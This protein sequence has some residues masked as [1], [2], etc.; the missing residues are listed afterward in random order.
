[1]KNKKFLIVMDIL[2]FFSLELVLLTGKILKNPFIKQK[3]EDTNNVDEVIETSADTMIHSSEDSIRD[4][5]NLDKTPNELYMEE[6]TKNKQ[7][8][9]T[10]SA[11]ET[12]NNMPV[13]SQNNGLENSSE[14]QKNIEIENKLEKHQN[15]FNDNYTSPPSK[16]KDDNYSQFIIEKTAK[17]DWNF[18]GYQYG[19]IYILNDGTAYIQTSYHSK[20]RTLIHPKAEIGYY[21]LKTPFQMYLKV[22]GMNDAVAVDIAT[23]SEKFISFPSKQY[24]Q[25]QNKLEDLNRRGLLNS[26]FSNS[27]YSEMETLKQNWNK[28]GY[29]QIIQLSDYSCWKQENSVTGTISENTSVFVVYNI[30]NDDTYL[31]ING[32]DEAIK[33]TE[34]H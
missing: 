6:I 17:I 20:L 32:V 25:Y 28:L 7:S 18:S 3:T 10:I 31:C 34:Y 21:S 5:S 9:D 4:S 24:G 11:S 23:V 12:K 15:S 14:Y 26:S 13:Y 19:N 1:M 22:E 29:G 8:N 16:E 27:Y 33:V 2:L 30:F